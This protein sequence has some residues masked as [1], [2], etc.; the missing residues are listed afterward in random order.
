MKER[1]RE[2]EKAKLLVFPHMLCV[3]VRLTAYPLHS[4]LEDLL[5]FDF[6]PQRDRDLVN[7]TR[8]RYQE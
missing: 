4:F 1:E 6:R 7:D 5:P 8:T 2:R 3:V